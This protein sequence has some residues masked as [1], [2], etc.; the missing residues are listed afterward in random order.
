M[1]IDLFVFNTHLGYL[2]EEKCVQT[3]KVFLE[4]CDALG[5]FKEYL[6]QGKIYTT[7]IGGQSLKTMLEDY[8]QQR[9]LGKLE[10]NNAIL[11]STLSYGLEAIYI[12]NIVGSHQVAVTNDGIV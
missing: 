3:Y 6:H 1:E 5:E 10:V 7:N 4:E 12:L 9:I 8:G 11:K 2:Q